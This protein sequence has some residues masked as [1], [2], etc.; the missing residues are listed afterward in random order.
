M[1]VFIASIHFFDPISYIPLGR[2]HVV[3]QRYSIAVGASVKLD[4][5]G[6]NPTV[7]EVDFGNSSGPQ[8]VL[9]KDAAYLHFP[10]SMILAVDVKQAES[11]NVNAF[12]ISSYLHDCFIPIA[13]CRINVALSLVI[14]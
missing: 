5:L 8:W 7:K 4:D 6:S 13:R 11:A 12:I 3:A 10:G 9:E 1:H 2:R 14:S